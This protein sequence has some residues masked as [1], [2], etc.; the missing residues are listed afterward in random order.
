MSV[1]ARSS[2]VPVP[3][4]EAPAPPRVESPNGVDVGLVAGIIVAVVI[5]IT[6]LLACAIVLLFLRRRS[7][8]FQMRTDSE[9]NQTDAKS[10]FGSIVFSLSN[11]VIAAAY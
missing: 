3:T 10:E 8:S 1:T 5:I 11:N 9:L 4:V 7:K 2:N 6:A